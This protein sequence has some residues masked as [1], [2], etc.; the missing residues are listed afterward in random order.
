MEKKSNLQTS[1]L[2]MI[3]KGGPGAGKGTQAKKLSEKYK[4]PHISSGDLLREVAKEDSPEGR[5]LKI[6]MDKGELAPNDLIIDIIEKRLN[7]PDC[8]KGF[9]LDGF[10]RARVEAKALEKILERQGRKPGNVIEIKISWEETLKRL[11]G[12]GRDDDKK[13]VIENRYK[14]YLK[15]AKEVIGY[16]KRRKNLCTEINGERKPE[17]ITEDLIELIEKQL[18]SKETI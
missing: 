1:P 14:I 9:I 8:R 4:I 12:R 17:F 7:K 18:E 2:F 13:E 10:P 16:F 15:E 5:R 11:A 3:I 6:L